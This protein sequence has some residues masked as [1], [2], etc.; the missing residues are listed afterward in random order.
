MIKDF[1]STQWALGFNEVHRN[2]AGLFLSSHKKKKKKKKKEEE[3][4]EGGW[5]VK[6]EEQKLQPL[7]Y[8]RQT[9]REIKST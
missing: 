3:E 6:E 7:I 9:I 8:Q 2:S 4:E 1:C 5:G